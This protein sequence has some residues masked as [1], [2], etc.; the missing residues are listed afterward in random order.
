MTQS[1]LIVALDCDQM[2]QA[3]AW[4]EQLDPRLC[5][6]KVGSEL[7][8]RCGEGL[9][10]R[11]IAQQFKVFLDLKFHD[12]PHTVARSCAV[13]ADLGVWMLTIHAAGGLA[14]MEA[15][16]KALAPLGTASPLLI[17]VTV[18]TSMSNSELQ[19]LGVKT[20]VSVETL[21]LAHLAQQA[22]M[23]GV[24]S[25]AIDVPRIKAACGAKFLSVTPGI[26]W[27]EDA[28][29]DQVR[30]VTPLQAKQLGSD[31][32][33]VGRSITT[34]DDP[35]SRVKLILQSLA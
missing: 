23:D 15:A 33:V 1:Q 3:L 8:T 17:A 19:H 26:R 16:R 35:A 7:F 30:V 10:R 14:M 29:H 6:V 27:A 4:V 9:V 24:V 31:Y 25:A 12:I 28:V 21:R 20:D 13:A 18:L 2:Q 32:L 5:A 34:A 11:L 22:G